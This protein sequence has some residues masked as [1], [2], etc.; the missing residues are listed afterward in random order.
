[1]STS[2]N[3]NSTIRACRSFLVAVLIATGGLAGADVGPPVVDPGA[4]SP[5]SDDLARAYYTGLSSTL[6]LTLTVGT[7]SLDDI[8]TFAGY[9]ASAN[10][11]QALDSSVLMDP[12][13]ASSCDAGLCLTA[14]SLGGATLR[15]GDILATRFFAPKIVNINTVNPTPGWRK[16]VR[17]Q[18]RSDSPAARAGVESIIVL[19]NSFSAAGQVPFPSSSVN[20]Q[21]MLLAPHLTPGL[22]WMDFDS[23]GRLA[24]ALNASFDAADLPDSTGGTRNYFVPDGC[25]ACHESPGNQRPPM[26]NYLD[27]DHWFDRLDTDFPALRDAGTALLFDAKTNDSTSPAFAQAFDVIRQFNEEALRQNSLA[28]PDSF[29]AQAGRTWLR[30]HSTT[31]AHLPAVVRGFSTTDGGAVWQASEADGLATLNRFCFRCHGSVLFS[32]FDRPAVVTRAANMRTRVNPSHAQAKI[33]GWRMPPDRSL[34]RTMT[35]AQLSQLDTFLR[36]LK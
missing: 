4:I 20:T 6:N 16:L 27:T 23:S 17:L 31:T 24:T 18:T 29:E 8:L 11:V 13:Q 14:T 25:N 30:L 3:P 19:F 35:P 21:M 33:P 28:Q 7:T 10:K 2:I 5:G 15:P 1:M 26:V 22:L 12:A 32:V 36:G 34:E 9:P